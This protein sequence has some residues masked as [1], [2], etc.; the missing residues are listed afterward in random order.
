MLLTALVEK[1]TGL[2]SKFIYLPVFI[3]ILFLLII[4]LFYYY[5]VLFS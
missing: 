2:D 3:Y 1:D 4:L 5:S